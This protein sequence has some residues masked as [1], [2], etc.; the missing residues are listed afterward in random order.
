MPR[1][2][3]P[4]ETVQKILDAALKLFLEKGYEQTTILDIVN[5]MG[6]MT[7]GAF[8]H[9][10]KSKEEVL[11]ALGDKLFLD[12]N[13]LE[14]VNQQ[15]NLTGL[16]KFKYILADS[17]EE[18]DSR[19]INMMSIQALKSPAFLKKMIDDNLEIV[20]PVYQKMIEEG[21][22][23]GSIVTEHPKLLAQLIVFLTSFWPLPTI[24][25]CSQ[26]E[27]IEKL[28]FTKE[29]TEKL[30]I[31]MLDDEMM[32]LILNNPAEVET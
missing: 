3:Y 22:E 19:K 27:S 31:P 4:E 12:N 23:D 16:D 8:Y 32:E 15:T 14:K 6:G 21:V 1:N 29:I 13:P 11:D 26:E 10:F 9:H 2:K 24:F 28:I 18:T 25:P 20:T 17:L 30:G 7:R 5:N